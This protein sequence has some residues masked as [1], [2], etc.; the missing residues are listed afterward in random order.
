MCGVLSFKLRSRW[1]N[2]FFM[3]ED[4]HYLRKCA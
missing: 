3:P 2:N 4:E 1:K